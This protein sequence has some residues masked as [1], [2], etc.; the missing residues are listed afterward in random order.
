[1][2]V[3]DDKIELSHQSI[4][5]LNGKIQDKQTAIDNA[6]KSIENQMNTLRNRLRNIYMAGNTTDLEIIFEQRAFLIFLIKWSL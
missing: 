3:L 4:N 1:M 6:N 2:Q 5:E